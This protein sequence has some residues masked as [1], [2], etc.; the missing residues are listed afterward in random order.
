MVG[1]SSRGS[2]GVHHRASRIREQRSPI[3]IL[4][5]RSV[6]RRGQRADARRDRP[7]LGSRCRW[8]HRFR[9]KIGRARATATSYDRSEIH[10]DASSSTPPAVPHLL[11][12]PPTRRTTY[13]PSGPTSTP[14]G[15]TRAGTRCASR[16]RPKETRGHPG[17]RGA[18]RAQ[19]RDPGA[20]R[21]ERAWTRPWPG[22]RRSRPDSW[23]TPTTTSAEVAAIG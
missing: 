9:G 20:G 3:V 10:I 22:R 14:D 16:R 6:R 4:R 11:R 17:R 19:C 21:D 23:P 7:V 1:D 13:P 5:A 8:I 15:S 2:P 12:A 18:D